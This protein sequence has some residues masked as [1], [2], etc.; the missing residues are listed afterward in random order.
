MVLQRLVECA[1]PKLRVH[2]ESSNK[3]S[4]LFIGSKVGRVY[5]SEMDNAGMNVLKILDTIHYM[6]GKEFWP[7]VSGI[8]SRC[9]YIERDIWIRSLLIIFS[10]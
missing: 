3:I 7:V 10:L 6:E 8:Q 2:S 9:I 4:A 5:L 1:P